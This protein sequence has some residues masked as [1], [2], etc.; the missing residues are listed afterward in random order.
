M[1][2]T[3]LGTPRRQRWR[4]ALLA[5]LV[6]GLIWPLL[7]AD[8]WRFYGS[9]SALIERQKADGYVLVGTFGR[10]DWPA[11]VVGRVA[12]RGTVA[13]VTAD[14]QPHQYQGFSGPLKAL[15]FRAGLAGGKTFT[16]VFHRP[17]QAPEVN[18][19]FAGIR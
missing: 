6:L 13:F 5:L 15:H 16:L 19:A 4:I 17:P 12:D 14:G 3:L 2:M 11:L 1:L 7:E 18:P 9:R 8:R 10:P